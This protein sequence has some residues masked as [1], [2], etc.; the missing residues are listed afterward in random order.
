ML[1]LFTTFLLINL[2]VI[3]TIITPTFIPLLYVLSNSEMKKSV[4]N[5]IYKVLFT[6]RIRMSSH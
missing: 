1:D 2:L 6:D 3:Y 5:L 4:E